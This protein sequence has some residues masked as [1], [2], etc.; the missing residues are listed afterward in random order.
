MTFVLDCSVAVTWFFE[1][2]ATPETDQLLAQLAD[3]DQALVTQHWML[4]IT[5]VLLGAEKEK[6][7]SPAETGQFLSL[8]GKLAIETD[9]ETGHAART[10]TLALAR[11]NQLTSHDA[12]YLELALRHGMP[13]AT[14]DHDLRKAARREG[15]RV[16][17]EKLARDS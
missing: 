15:V 14:L 8:L 13:L 3:A 9:P 7:K 12:A 1:H 10:T 17:P 4:A 5:N 2:E 16:L 6:K 11:K